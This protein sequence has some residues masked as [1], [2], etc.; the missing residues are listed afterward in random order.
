[1]KRA[2]SAKNS[3]VKLIFGKILP[4]NQIW[5]NSNLPLQDKDMFVCT[6]GKE[7]KAAEDREW[8]VWSDLAQVWVVSLSTDNVILEAWG[9]DTK[10]GKSER[11]GTQRRSVKLNTIKE[12]FVSWTRIDQDRK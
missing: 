6:M 12:D 9:T 1:M 8:K 5:D 2:S 3:E 10:L 4:I 11:R 7:A